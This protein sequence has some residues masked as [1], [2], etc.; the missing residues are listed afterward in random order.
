MTS[1]PKRRPDRIALQ[2]CSMPG[3]CKELPTERLPDRMKVPDLIWC[4]FHADEVASKIAELDYKSL[5][6]ALAR[7]GVEGEP[8]LSNGLEVETQ[9]PR[10][11]VR[12]R[13]RGWLQLRAMYATRARLGVRRS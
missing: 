6:A 8:V 13:L 7:E 3:G 5:T 11:R 9:V 4:K 12:G 2:K 10:R 1:Q